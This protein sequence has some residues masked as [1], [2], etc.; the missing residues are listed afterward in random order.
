MPQD[1][2]ADLNS[3]EGDATP[4]DATMLDSSD[5]ENSEGDGDSDGGAGNGGNENGMSFCELPLV[6]TQS[7]FIVVVV[8]NITIEAS[9][10]LLTQLARTD[11]I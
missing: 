6:I 1:Q 9:S 11:L 5:M 8:I 4:T 2:D 10:Q 3:D 7:S